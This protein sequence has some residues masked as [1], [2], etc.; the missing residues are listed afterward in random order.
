[1]YGFCADILSNIA[2]STLPSSSRFD[3]TLEDMFSSGDAADN[4]LQQSRRWETL[5]P[6]RG[7]RPRF[8]Y[9]IEWATQMFERLMTALDQRARETNDLNA[10]GLRTSRL[11]VMDAHEHLPSAGISEASANAIQAQQHCIT[12]DLQRALA[13]GST[14]FPK[15]QISSDR[16]EARYLAS[17]ESNGKWFAVSKVLLTTCIC[18]GKDARIADLPSG[19]V[20]V[21]R[22][23]CADL[24]VVAPH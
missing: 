6:H 11:L 18:Q 24:L 14:A 17:V 5:P 1:M 15:S 3:L 16:R 21:L 12:S 4:K 10:S 20:N 19:L 8:E 13:T 2:L 23:S 22:L 7:G 9:S